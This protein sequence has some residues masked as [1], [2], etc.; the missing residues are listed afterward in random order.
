MLLDSL[1]VH[2][3][4]QRSKYISGLKQFSRNQRALAARINDE[5]G[6]LRDLEAQATTAAAT[7]ATD[8]RQAWTWD[9]RIYDERERSLHLLCQQPVLLDQRVFAL[10]RA[11]AEELE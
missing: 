6:R 7:E 5:T 8:L 9:T 4:E 1:L 11:L 3:N 2:A 10:A